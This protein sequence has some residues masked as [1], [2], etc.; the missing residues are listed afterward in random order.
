MISWAVWALAV[1]RTL[2]AGLVNAVVTSPPLLRA[3]RLRRTRP[4]RPGSDPSD[5]IATMRAVFAEVARVLAADG[6]LWLN[7]GDIY[8]GKADGSAGM[9]RGADRAGAMPARGNTTSEAPGSHRGSDQGKLSSDR[10]QLSP[11]DR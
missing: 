10:R 5:F 9:T 6:T 2:P 11:G 7:L 4:V 8:A 3:A 1:L